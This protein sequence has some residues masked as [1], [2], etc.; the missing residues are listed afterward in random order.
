MEKAIGNIFIDFWDVLK[1]TFIKW[2][3][4]DPFRQSAIVAFYAIFSLPAL[5]FIII[6]VAGYFWGEDAIEGKISEEIAGMIGSEAANIIEVMVAGAAEQEDSQLMFYI[7]LAI[8]LFT[9]TTVFYHLQKSLNRVWGIEA[10]PEKAW[11]KYLIDRVFS[12]GMVLSIGF[13]MLISL[14]VTSLLTAFGNWLQEY[15]PD[16][17]MVI[18]HI[19]NILISLAVITTLFALMFKVLPDAKIK[20]KSVWIGSFVTAILFEIGKYALSLYFG[21]TDPASAYGGA[22]A[23][24]LILLWV[25]Y[26]CLILFFGAEFT[27]QYAKKFGHGV[28][29]K[30]GAKW[31]G[32][33]KE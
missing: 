12:F 14:V 2:N 9:S 26:V 23:I 27:L 28:K 3:E 7:G 10:Q 5:L 30:E 8:V 19:L 32:I 22:G 31:V 4:I 16:V 11:L 15:V 20:W 29:L 6:F 1:Q 13:L 25:S 24:V 21:E 33:Q 18:F 17:L